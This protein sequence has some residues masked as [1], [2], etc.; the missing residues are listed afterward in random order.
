MKRHGVDSYA[1][2]VRQA[3][4]DPEWF[5]HG[6]NVALGIQWFRPYKRVMDDSAGQAW[7]RWFVGGSINVA[8]NCLDR[9]V[10]A[11]RG[12]RPAIHWESEDG[13]SRSL[14]YSELAKETAQL[15]NGL[16]RLGIGPLDRVGIHLPMCP[17]AVIAFLALAKLGAISVP[18]FSGFGAKAIAHRL[19]DSGAKALIT[20]DGFLRRGRPIAVKDV[21]DEALL[22]CPAVSHVIVRERLALPVSLHP[23]RDHTWAAITEGEST[24]FAP[25]PLDSEHPLLIAYT[26]GTTGK[27]KGAVH[28][29]G[30]FLVKIAAEAVYQ[31]DVRP[32]DLLFWFTDLGWIMGPWTIVGGLSQGAALR[33]YDGAPDHPTPDRV[34]SLIENRGVTIFGA[35]PTLIRSLMGRCTPPS[36]FDLSTLR[37]LGSTGEPWNGDAWNWYF[38]EVGGGRCPVIN[39]SG[40]T[41]VGACLLSTSIAMPIKSCSVGLPALGMA[42]DVF[43]AEGRPIES[44]VGELVC[45]KP[46]PGMTRG[47][48]NDPERYLATYWPHGDSAW[49]QGDWASIDA[50]GD[51]FLH[52]RSDDTLKIAGKR[53]GP[54]EIETVLIAHP[55]IRE[56]AVIGL[57]DEVKGETI[58]AVVVFEDE[59]A[60]DGPVLLHQ[61]DSLMNEAVGKAFLVERIW[62]ISELPRTRSGKVVRRVLRAA[63]TGEPRGDVSTIENPEVLESLRPVAERAR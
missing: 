23:R 19:T 14:T 60:I 53:I 35:S 12:D 39:F 59:S 51:W 58:C 38:E 13:T 27:P 46:W 41:E 20:V 32:E 44:G 62:E 50:D 28:V 3:S 25:R 49:Y 31:T 55:A 33:L 26:S 16:E 40:G 24:E 1:Q 47:L 9:H 4:F 48:W 37:I 2:L 56:A 34:W 7:T 29:H 42:V 21:V 22:L 5:W 30:G 6:V 11:G 63:V 57:P 43:D 18:I 10:I 52:G 36:S 8:H 45:T 17:E 54:A 61:V 15:A